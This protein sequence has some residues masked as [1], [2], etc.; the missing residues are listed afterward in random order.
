[1]VGTLLKS[2][3]PAVGQGPTMQAGFSKDRKLLAVLTIFCTAPILHL[4]MWHWS[5]GEESGH[6]IKQTV[7][8]KEITEYYKG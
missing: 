7:I 8:Y 6:V 5:S 3:S 2:E 1:M 4:E